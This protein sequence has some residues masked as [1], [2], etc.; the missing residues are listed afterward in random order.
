[1]YHSKHTDEQ[2]YGHTVCEHMGHT[3]RFIHI[4]YNCPSLKLF[5]YSS[6]TAI[7]RAISRKL[8][9]SGDRR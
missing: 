6:E 2:L 8:K 7:K 1:M 4:S 9:I 5:G 3:I